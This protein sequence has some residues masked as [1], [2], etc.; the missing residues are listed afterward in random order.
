MIS[1]FLKFALTSGI[2]WIIDFTIYSILVY[3]FDVNVSTAN[4]I[5]AL[6]A[7]T[8]VFIVSTRKTFEKNNSRIPLKFKYLIYVVYQFVLV[9]LVSIFAGFLNSLPVEDYISISL[10]LDFKE[11][12]IKCIITCITLVCNFFTMRILTE[13]I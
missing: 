8:F 10:I 12:I 5:S 2:G 13:K 11:L 1:I 7:I 3:L 9:S 6:P 4:F